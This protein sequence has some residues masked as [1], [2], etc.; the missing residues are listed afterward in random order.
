SCVF[1]RRRK[2]HRTRVPAIGV[3]LIGTKRGH[4]ELETVLEYNDHTEMR[5]DRVRSR[6]K[7]LHIF[8]ASVG[9]DVVILWC[10]TAHHV[11]HATTCEVRN[12]SPLTQPLRDP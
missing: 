5:T 1:F 3:S 2:M 10:Q 12:V 6:E 11:A 8:R 4:L 9:G 7:R